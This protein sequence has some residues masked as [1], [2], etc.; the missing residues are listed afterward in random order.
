MVLKI[1]F[2]FFGIINFFRS[3]RNKN[4]CIWQL[5]YI[6]KEETSLSLSLSC[7]NLL[8]IQA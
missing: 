2:M 1:Y 7:L 3:K 8:N 6:F 4:V 5:N